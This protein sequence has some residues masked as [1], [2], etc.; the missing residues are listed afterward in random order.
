MEKDATLPLMSPTAPDSDPGFNPRSL[1]DDD[2]RKLMALGL[3]RSLPF[4]KAVVMLQLHRLEQSEQR[5]SAVRDHFVA[6][7]HQYAANNPVMNH[8]NL[9]VLAD[10]HFLVISIGQ[11]VRYGRMLRDIIR[12]SDKSAG[13]L[14]GQF[15]SKWGDPKQLRNILEH[16][17][18]YPSG[19]KVDPGKGLGPDLWGFHVDHDGEHIVLVIGNDRIALV[20]LGQS[21]ARL[22]ADL[23]NLW[24]EL[25]MGQANS[26]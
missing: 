18:R 10:S 21:A 12:T 14:L 20:P 2:R 19:R 16:F 23:D 6:N 26:D 5:F 25:T 9:E 7:V 15:E 22:A 24:C 4:W 13:A 11:V 17:D 8:W 3:G 1:S